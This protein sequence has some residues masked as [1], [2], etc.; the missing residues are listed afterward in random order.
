[1]KKVAA[2][3]L[4]LFA[5]S[6]CVKIT[7]VPLNATPL[8]ENEATV[9]VFH[10]LGAR[11]TF[12][13]FLDKEPIGIV[14]SEK[15]LKFSVKPGEHSLHT[16]VNAAIDRVSTQSYEAGKIYFMRIWLDMGVFVNSIRIDPTYARESYIVRK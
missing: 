13:V 1:M 7:H 2:I 14:S 8:S 11:D 16:E 10:E 9:I 12:K 15:P 4:F 3:L 5:L 6:G